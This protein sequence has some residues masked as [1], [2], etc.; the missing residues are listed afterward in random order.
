M[1][2]FLPLTDDWPTE[3]IR[4]AIGQSSLTFT[5]ARV[6]E[7]LVLDT[8]YNQVEEKKV[9]RSSQHGFSKGKSCLTNLIA[10]YDI[11]TGW[12]DG[13]RAVD[14]LYLD[15]SKAFDTVSHSI[16][17]MKLGKYGIDEQKVRW[18]DNWMTGRAQSTVIS[19][20]VWLEARK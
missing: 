16:L 5:P 1:L 9:I 6:T 8:F 12:V 14:V 11:M 20:A 7:Q 10:F 2:D 15:F 17:V 19:S 3:W 13:R 18:I 4:E